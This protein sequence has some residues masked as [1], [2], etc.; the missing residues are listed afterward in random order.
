[1]SSEKNTHMYRNH[2][3]PRIKMAV[4]IF[5]V[6]AVVAGINIFV[7]KMDDKNRWSKDFSVN[8]QFS[9]SDSTY[10]MLASIDQEI[11]IYTLFPDSVESTL[12]TLVTEM[13]RNYSQSENVKVENIDILSNPAAVS[14]FVT[15]DT[16][17]AN[18][19]VIVCNADESLFRVI[20]GN[21][22]FCYE[23][24]YSTQTYSKYDF[25]GEQKV[26]SAISYVTGNETNRV[27]LL[28]GHGEPDASSL[29]AVVDSLNSNNYEVIKWSLSEDTDISSKDVILV[30]EPTM[31]LSSMECEILTDYLE[32][33][34]NLYYASSFGTGTFRNFNRLFE[35]FG[36]KMSDELLVENEG[37]VEFYYRNR[38]YNMPKLQY[39]GDDGED[40]DEM[41]RFT[42]GDYVVLPQCRAV[43]KTT[44]RPVGCDIHDLAVTSSGAYLKKGDSTTI[45]RQG[46][47]ERSYAIFVSSEK[48]FENGVR[49]RIVCLGNGFVFSTDDLFAAFSN[50]KLLLSPLEW[51]S[52]S[53]H[54]AEV[55]GKA[56]GSYGLSI[57]SNTTYQVM[58]WAVIGALPLLILISGLIIWR[59]RRRK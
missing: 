15:A 37:Y 50:R 55:P 45:D 10:E 2:I 19:S 48:T 21:D 41:T 44:I 7:S 18:N 30:I 35:Q 59:V 58:S 52:D 25:V 20:P 36:I 27:F 34:C 42:K 38:L 24:D 23:I 28:R 46:E 57:P 40:Y 6:I 3:A 29:K 49:S 22:F 12:K 1:M 47:E 5:A 9:I 16:T 51:L 4:I 32:K 43:L 31:D 8:N 13:L 14:R 11:R 33:G 17:P 53:E 56:M 26:N 39:K 54:V